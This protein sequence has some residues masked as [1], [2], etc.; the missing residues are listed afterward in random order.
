VQQKGSLVAPDRLRFDF[1][2]FEAITPEELL[3]IERLVNAQIRLNTP[4]ETRLMD[5]DSAVA[6]GAMALFGEKY[7]RDV[8]VLRIGDFSME[9]CGGT[10]VGRSGDI[11]L[12][13]IV[14]E[15]G[16]AA[17]VRRIEALTGEAAVDYVERN[18]ALLK[19]VANLLR[20]SREDVA[21]KVRDALER[22]RQM[23]KEIRTLKDRLASGQG[24]D[25][26]SGAVDVHGVKVVATKVDGADAGALRTAVDRLKDKLKSAVIVLASVES[27]SKVIL[28]TG[29]TSDQT[30]RIKAGELAGQIAAQIGG[31]GGGR[32][33]FAQAGGTN[34][35][36]LEAALESVQ[37]FVRSRLS[38]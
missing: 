35:E 20:G 36:A 12:F 7:D 8:R 1:S 11:G 28:V 34:P 5:Y 18:D 14:G 3:E 23:E 19:D 37:E 38:T 4:A 9:L 13:K 29:V 6:S 16:V 10:H 17:G 33:D 25:L 27:P 26:A 31:R 2:H 21:D 15:S 32:P 22:I 30:S 24:V